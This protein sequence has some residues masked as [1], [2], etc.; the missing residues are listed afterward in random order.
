M[1]HGETDEGRYSD[2]IQHNMKTDIS[3]ILGCK[4]VK[5]RKKGETAVF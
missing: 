2:K 1:R 5:L 4:I 3:G